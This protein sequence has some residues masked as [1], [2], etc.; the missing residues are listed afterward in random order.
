M[1]GVVFAGKMSRWKCRFS[2]GKRVK[3]GQGR[4]RG[5]SKCSPSAIV[6]EGCV[7]DDGELEA[8]QTCAVSHIAVNEAEPRW[9]AS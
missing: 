8:R 9:P 3:L 5:W 6:D 1:S 2:T 7:G 4:G